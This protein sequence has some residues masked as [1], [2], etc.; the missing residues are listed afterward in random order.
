M[1]AVVEQ[2]ARHYQ[3]G[4]FERIR[5]IGHSDTSGSAAENLE[6]SLERAEAVR[7]RLVALGLP[8]FMIEVVARGES[9]PAVATGD[10]VAEALNRRVVIEVRD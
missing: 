4:G 5:L 2:A 6:I 1:N 3:A 7:D 10:G 8:L 9:D